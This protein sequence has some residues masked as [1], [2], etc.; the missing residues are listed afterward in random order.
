MK[1]RRTL[2]ATVAALALAM[3]AGL[4]LGGCGPPDDARASAPDDPAIEAIAQEA[5]SI[6][7]RASWPAGRNPDGSMAPEHDWRTSADDGSWSR[8]GTVPAAD[9]ASDG[10]LAAT[11]TVPKDSSETSAEFCVAARNSVGMSP[12]ACASYTVPALALP[13]STPGTP[14]VD[15]TTALETGTLEVPIPDGAEVPP[16]GFRV[17]INYGRYAQI[18]GPGETARFRLP[19]GRHVVRTRCVDDFRCDPDRDDGVLSHTLVT[20]TPERATRPAIA[21]R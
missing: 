9:S 11:F 7:F 3:L 4:A 8:E 19:I 15:S 18:A 17:E 21:G 6:S 14:S 1:T 13:P 5:D 20:V 2:L 12:E 10:T 16:A